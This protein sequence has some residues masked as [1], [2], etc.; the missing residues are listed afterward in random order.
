MASSGATC[1][2]QRPESASQRASTDA[3]LSPVLREPFALRAAQ[4][5]SKSLTVE[6]HVLRIGRQVGRN[7]HAQTIRFHGQ[8]TV[9][10]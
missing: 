5:S 1:P 7:V 10:E 9:V 6:V 4:P 8:P 2:E 3:M